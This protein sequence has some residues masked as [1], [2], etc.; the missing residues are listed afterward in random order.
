M[1]SLTH[2]NEKTFVDWHDHC[3]HQHFQGSMFAC[4][5][6]EAQDDGDKPKRVRQIILS[7]G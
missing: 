4:D 7:I 2:D 3:K 1:T 6:E 5:G